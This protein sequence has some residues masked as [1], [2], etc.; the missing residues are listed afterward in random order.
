MKERVL[1][2]KHLRE[3]PHIII[4]SNSEFYGACRHKSRFH[5]YATTTSLAVLMTDGSPERVEYNH[6]NPRNADTNNRMYMLE[7]QFAAMDINPLAH[8][9]EQWG[10]QENIQVDV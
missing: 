9:S 6:T 5:W 8:I 1:I 7:E 4:N 2:L 3:N 10:L